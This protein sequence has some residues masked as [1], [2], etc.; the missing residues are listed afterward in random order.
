MYGVGRLTRV[1][2][3]AN[4]GIISICRNIAKYEEKRC[5]VL[6]FIMFQLLEMQKPRGMIIPVDL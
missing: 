2:H 6:P 1:F 4:T 3:T 5:S